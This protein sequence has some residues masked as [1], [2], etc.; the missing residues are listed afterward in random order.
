[1]NVSY[2]D[3]LDEEILWYSPHTLLLGLAA[4]EDRKW[5]ADFFHQ[6]H[7]DVFDLYRDPDLLIPRWLEF[8]CF[9]RVID[10]ATYQRIVPSLI[11]YLKD[12]DPETLTPTVVY[13]ASKNGL[14][15]NIAVIDAS[16]TLPTMI[17]GLYTF[18][19]RNRQ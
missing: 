16:R 13:G 18:L 17:T 9:L 5:A 7:A 1:M 6:H 14:A 12:E 4:D 8:P 11:E 19:I 2:I 3:P 15:D 10:Y